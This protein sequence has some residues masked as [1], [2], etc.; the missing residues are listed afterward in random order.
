MKATI[1]TTSEYFGISEEELRAIIIPTDNYSKEELVCLDAGEDNGHFC[2]GL[3]DALETALYLA[4]QGYNE[5]VV[6]RSVMNDPDVYTHVVICS[7]YE[8]C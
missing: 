3:V 4:K 6:L 1:P 8:P 2:Y 7:D 5:V